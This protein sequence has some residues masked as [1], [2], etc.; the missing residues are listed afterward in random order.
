MKRFNKFLSVVLSVAMIVSMLSAVAFA[1]ESGSDATDSG[2]NIV[3]SGSSETETTVGGNVISVG[4]QV[5]KFHAINDCYEAAE[6]SYTNTDSI[7]TILEGKSIT[8]KLDAEKAGNYAI[9]LNIDKNSTANKVTITLNDEVYDNYYPMANRNWQ[10]VKYNMSEAVSTDATNN[11]MFPFIEGENILTITAT[12]CDLKFNANSHIMIRGLDIVAG[13]GV[14]FYAPD[15][16]DSNVMHAHR[17]NQYSDGINE[18]VTWNDKTVQGMHIAAGKYLTYNIDAGEGGYYSVKAA[19]KAGAVN[20]ASLQKVYVNGS[21]VAAASMTVPAKEAI[22]YDHYDASSYI[23]LQAGLNTV[24]F[25]CEVPNNTTHT[26]A[27]IS[28]I[29][30]VKINN[31]SYNVGH[32]IKLLPGQIETTVKN[33]N[34]QNYITLESGEYVTARIVTDA[35]DYKITS[36]SGLTLVV[37]DE[38]KENTL[39]PLTAT[40]HTI[41]LINNTD[42]AVNFESV[43]ILPTG[44]I[45]AIT[46]KESSVEAV[47]GVYTIP[48]T[49]ATFTLDFEATKAGSYDF[50]VQWKNTT[51]AIGYYKA[52]LTNSEDSVVAE[53]DNL[54]STSGV[55]ALA[56]TGGK[57]KDRII[58]SAPDIAAGTYTLTF[59]IYESADALGATVHGFQSRYVTYTAPEDNTELMIPAINLV[60]ADAIPTV[61]TDKPASNCAH[62]YTSAASNV[63]NELYDG[64]YIDFHNIIIGTNCTLSYDIVSNKSGYYNVGFSGLP[65]T[66]TSADVELYVN[67]VKAGVVTV[68]TNVDTRYDFSESVFLNEGNNT[69]SLLYAASGG[70]PAVQKLYVSNGTM[71]SVSTTQSTLVA[72]D[73]PISYVDNSYNP[74]NISTNVK[75]LEEGDS[76]TVKVNVAEKHIYAIDATFNNSA[77]DSSGASK[78]VNPVF[79]VVID[80]AEPVT[81]ETFRGAVK[82]IR[83][84]T[85]CEL[86]KGIHT[87]TLTLKENAD[88]TVLVNF[89]N[90]VL[91]NTEIEVKAD[92]TATQFGSY[93]FTD[94]ATQFAPVHINGQF[95]YSAYADPENPSSDNMLGGAIYVSAGKD[96]TYT[97]NAEEDG[98]YKLTAFASI[99]NKRTGTGSEEDPYVYNP[100]TPATISY[101]VNGLETASAVATVNNSAAAVN[102]EGADQYGYK[103]ADYETADK[104][105]YL[106]KGLNTVTLRVTV[107]AGG[108]RIY[109][110]SIEKINPVI[111][112]TNEN[113]TAIGTT[114]LAAGTYTVT[115]NT[116]GIGNNQDILVSFVVYKTKDGVTTMSDSVTKV[117]TDNGT[118]TFTGTVTVGNEEGYTYTAKMI[119]LDKATFKVLHTV[120]TYTY[121]AEPE[122]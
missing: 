88:Y 6:G 21:A 3:E 53:L 83:T 82:E 59:E 111:T 2:S 116:N 31:A 45:R 84:L 28:K 95:G 41:K 18:S 122:A 40:T 10:G 69:I 57:V 7:P 43:E 119:I 118:N 54:P 30:L 9:Y 38:V 44:N 70:Y 58:L 105:V 46:P 55:Y 108:I 17:D 72:V 33:A 94:C 37:D 25:A 75:E 90:F 12:I 14:S 117:Y 97:F 16:V 64:E 19:L 48:D 77:T 78:N 92:G 49:G 113:S 26:S 87:I 85:R 103:Y 93:E 89:Y 106:N 115:A 56:K 121:V 71:P 60:Y 101:F 52:T 99:D 47:D 104:Y 79:D 22:S 91:R 5:T 34:A 24:K 80:D 74:G 39:V 11:V 114:E 42:S 76:V 110:A 20:K 66:N 68:A 67:G 27:W 109:K 8:Y 62:M 102:G 107:T 81:V 98:M 86:D 15:Y 65:L 13:D 51:N 1:T 100:G 61:K 36:N 23:Y 73:A 32:G 35:K 112:V 96:L 4:P 63:T 120:D 50:F 29:E